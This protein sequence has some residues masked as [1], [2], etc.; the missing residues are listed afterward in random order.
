M[1]RKAKAE[2]VSAEVEAAKEMQDLYQQM[3]N[4]AQADRDHYKEERNELRDR[5]NE[6]SKEVSE[7]K[8]SAE[9]DRV[10]MKREISRL[11][12]K[13]DRMLPFLC[14]DLNCKRRQRVV[15]SGEEGVDS[16]LQKLTKKRDIEPYDDRQDA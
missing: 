14:A 2:A 11:E 3:V 13:V 5:M 4:D 16:A 9:D 12:N 10:G 7:W 15:V 6:F 1:S 8:H